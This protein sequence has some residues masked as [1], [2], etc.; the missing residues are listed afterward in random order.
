MPNTLRAEGKR[1]TALDRIDRAQRELGYAMEA[2]SPVIGAM[3]EWEKAGALYDSVKALW[4]R[5]NRLTGCR[6][7]SEDVT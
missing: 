2:L 7:D 1:L 4:H 6:L 3:P 5:V